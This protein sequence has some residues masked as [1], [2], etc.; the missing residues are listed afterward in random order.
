MLTIEDVASELKVTPMTIY[1]A[2]KLGKVRGV[3]I[4]AIW[5]ISEDELQRVIKEG[6]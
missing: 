5:R 6:F 1:R 3:K 2:L 4:G